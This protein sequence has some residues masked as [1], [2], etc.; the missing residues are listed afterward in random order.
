VVGAAMMAPVA[1]KDRVFSVS[2]DRITSGRQAPSYAHRAAQSRHNAS[3]SASACAAS[4][5]GG[6]GRWDG[7]QESTNSVASPA[8]MSKLA[9]V[10]PSWPCNGMAVRRSTRLGPAIA[11]MPVV[12]S[13]CV[14]Q[15]VAE[16]YSK[17]STS[18][19]CMLTRPVRPSTRRTMAG[20]SVPVGM[21][22]RTATLPSAV[23]NRV[24]R[25]MVSPR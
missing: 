22:S 11:S 7:P 17:R 19:V 25:I 10:A 18:W 2:S 1:A 21:K 5:G 15:G 8:A 13:S 9:T 20:M 24:S 4:N 6:G 23:S 14:T 3:V 16:P 12:V